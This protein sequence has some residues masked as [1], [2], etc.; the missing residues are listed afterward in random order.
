MASSSSQSQLANRK[1]AISSLLQILLDQ[2]RLLRQE[3]NVRVRV[4]QERPEPLSRLL[5]R[6]GEFSLLLIAPRLL[7]CAHLA[8]QPRHESLKLV[9]EPVEVGGETP[10]L[11][12]VDAGFSHRDGPP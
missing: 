4:F 12:W 5:E 8:V 11:G 9:I 6:L 10:Q 1:W 7:Q 3:L 2:R